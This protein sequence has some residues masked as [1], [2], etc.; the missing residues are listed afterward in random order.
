MVAI[1]HFELFASDLP[2]K[3]SFRHA[4]AVR[5]VSDS[6]FLRCQL[7]N[8]VAG[9]GE[10]LPRVYVT[11]ESRDDACAMLQHGILPKL[12]GRRFAA[13]EEVLDFLHHCNGAAP[14]DWVA[15]DSAQTAAWC[16]VDLALLDA[17]GK[18]FAV[19]VLDRD[20]NIWPQHTQPLRYSGVL[21]SDRGL[22]LL[23]SALK[24]RLF[25][26]RSIKLKLDR[27]TPPSAI[28]RARRILGASARLRADANMCWSLEEAMARIEELQGYGVESVEQPLAAA[29][30]GGLAALRHGCGVDIMADE[31]LTDAASMKAIVKQR[32]VNAV[33]V[34]IAKCGGLIAARRRCREALQAGLK[35]QIGCQV[36]ESS[37]LSAA[38]MALI[39]S[40]K[41]VDYIE[42]CFGRF[43]LREDPAAPSLTFRYGGKPPPLPTGVGLGV[44]IDEA[45]LRRHS[46]QRALVGATR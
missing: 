21:S 2:F 15:P 1:A 7:S 4:A 46:I 41:K 35:L 29:D 31:S 38:Q 9:Y 27:D 19:A 42:G 24:M 13:M 10:S 8:G 20:R 34:R 6:L 30:L 45:V 32:A 25:G 44:H 37:L 40:I 22:A 17:C 23:R 43:L 12:V 16:A 36:G 26:L 39:A 33:N 28:A 14:T 18:A 3:K 11:G 5:G